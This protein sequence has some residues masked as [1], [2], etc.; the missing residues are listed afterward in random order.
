METKDCSPTASTDVPSIR[1][2][3]RK[4]RH[5]LPVME[6]LFAEKE[7]LIEITS[8]NKEH[9]QFLD[10]IAPIIAMFSIIPLM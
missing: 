2:R 4:G 6:D 9:Y 8:C 1:V 7:N 10:I 3:C 5:M